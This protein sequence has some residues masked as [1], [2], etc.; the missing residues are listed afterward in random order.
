MMLVLVANCVDAGQHSI[1]A[2]FFNT[3]TMDMLA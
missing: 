1:V 3:T 2:T